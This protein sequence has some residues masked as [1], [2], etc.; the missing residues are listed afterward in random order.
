MTFT[1]KIQKSSPTSPTT[2]KTTTKT[3]TNNNKPHLRTCSNTRGQKLNFVVTHREKPLLI[4][5]IRRFEE[6]NFKL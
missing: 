1:T 3:T 5:S 6:K 2:T 4:H